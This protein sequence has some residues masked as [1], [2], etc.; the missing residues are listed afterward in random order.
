MQEHVDKG[1]Q[2]P[3]SNDELPIGVGLAANV[4]ERRGCLGL[5]PKIPVVLIGYLSPPLD[6]HALPE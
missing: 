1:R 5:P 2:A 4:A 6:K 3:R